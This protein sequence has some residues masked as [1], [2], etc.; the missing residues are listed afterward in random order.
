MKSFIS[1][2]S[3]EDA[4]KLLVPIIEEE[5]ILARTKFQQA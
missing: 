4:I 5:A 3:V 2:G 1:A